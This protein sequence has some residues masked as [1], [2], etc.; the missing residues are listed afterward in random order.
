MFKVAIIFTVIGVI[1]YSVATIADT[2]LK[3]KNRKED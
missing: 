1:L 3:K 2:I